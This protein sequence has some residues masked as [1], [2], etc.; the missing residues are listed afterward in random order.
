MRSLFYFLIC[1]VLA[2]GFVRALR[3]TQQDDPA[4]ANSEL[5]FCR[6]LRSIAADNPVAKDFEP[7]CF[8]R[9]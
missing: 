5:L 2:V 7:K 9:F 4:V 3:P 1:V 8:S 6:A